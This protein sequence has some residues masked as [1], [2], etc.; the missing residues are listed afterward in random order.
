[1]VILTTLKVSGVF[2]APWAVAKIVLSPKPSL[3]I[4][5]RPY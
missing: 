2:E 1:M 5:L 4:M 3:Q